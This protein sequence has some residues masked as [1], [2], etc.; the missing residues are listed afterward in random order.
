MKTSKGEEADRA[1][2]IF[3]HTLGNT[4]YIEKKTKWQSTDFI[5]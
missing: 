2:K 1:S 3:T 4:V 5:K